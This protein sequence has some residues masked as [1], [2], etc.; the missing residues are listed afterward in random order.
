MIKV[1]HAVDPYPLPP[2]PDES[3]LKATHQCVV[4]RE[5]PRIEKHRQGTVGKGKILG[6]REKRAAVCE[7]LKPAMKLTDLA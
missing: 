6:N 2:V 1:V 7:A 5:H 3:L 4:I